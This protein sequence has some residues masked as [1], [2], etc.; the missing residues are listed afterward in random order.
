MMACGLPCVELASE[1]MQ[2]TFGRDGQPTLAPADPIALCAAVQ[3]LLAHPTPRANASAR[4]IELM[5]ERTWGARPCRWSMHCGSRSAHAP[6]RALGSARMATGTAA[7]EAPA[8]R[9]QPSPSGRVAAA[10]R[11]I[12]RIPRVLAL[13]VLVGA[14]QSLAWDVVSPPSR[15]PTKPPT[16]GRSNTSPKRGASP[17]RPAVT[18]RTRRKRRRL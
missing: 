12:A 1:S 4:G 3:E 5:A 14:L 11:R 9:R 10:R 17:A 18:P 2:R 6:P 8:W 13:L 15:D 16:S 7:R